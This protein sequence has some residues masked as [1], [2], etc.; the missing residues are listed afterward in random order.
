[1]TP[2]K[3][4]GGL[5][6]IAAAAVSLPAPAAQD[7]GKKFGIECDIIY[8]PMNPIAAVGAFVQN[9]LSP[10]AP[11]SQALGAPQASAAGVLSLQALDARHRAMCLGL[12]H[13][14]CHRSKTS[15]AALASRASVAAS[16]KR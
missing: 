3:L 5:L 9:L 13:G 7:G 11:I 4:A 14:P 16:L 15:P 6:L 10:V 1:M 2:R 8:V 12:D